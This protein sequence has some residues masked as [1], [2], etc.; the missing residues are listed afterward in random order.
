MMKAGDSTDAV[1]SR[2]ITENLLRCAELTDLC[3]QLRLA[4]LKQEYL[5]HEAR[6]KVMSEVRQAK[7]QAWRRNPS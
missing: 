7:E 1:E 6:Q 3:L 5:D 2:R 4:V